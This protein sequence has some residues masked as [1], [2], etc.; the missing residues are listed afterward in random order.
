ME[1][2]TDLSRQWAIAA[3]IAAGATFATTAS[4]ALATSAGAAPKNELTR[5]IHAADHASQIHDPALLVAC[6]DFFFQNGEHDSPP[7]SFNRVIALGYRELELEP[8]NTSIYAEVAWLL[9]SKYATWTRAPDQ[10]PDGESKAREAVEL[11]LSGRKHLNGEASFHMEAGNTI[12]PLARY[13]L[14][15]YYAFTIESFERADA[16]AP[17]AKTRVRARLNLGHIHRELGD[18]EPAISWYRKVL[19]IEP[20]NAVAIKYLKQLGAAEKLR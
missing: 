18:R 9:Y 5:C 2:A 1:W 4:G 19:D 20:K 3:T 16:L 12:W 17:P 8:R 6:M 11:L 13:H 15:E 7:G 10:M 14:P